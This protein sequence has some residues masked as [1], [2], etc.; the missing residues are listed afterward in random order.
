[1]SRHPPIREGSTDTRRQWERVRLVCRR[2]AWI[3]RSRMRWRDLRRGSLLIIRP[4]Y[5]T[6]EFRWRCLADPFGGLWSGQIVCGCFASLRG[7]FWDSSYRPSE[8]DTGVEARITVFG[9][10]SN[11]TSPTWNASSGSTGCDNELGSAGGSSSPPRRNL[12][13]RQANPG[14]LDARLRGSR[15]ARPLTALPQKNN[16]FNG[17]HLLGS[18]GRPLSGRHLS[19]RLRSSSP[20]GCAI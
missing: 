19:L 11:T 13:A 20:Y 3:G 18:T 7:P 10:W 12:R 2:S 9:A 14:A 17:I 8:G 16:L 15:S 5:T 6:A 1:M 4:K